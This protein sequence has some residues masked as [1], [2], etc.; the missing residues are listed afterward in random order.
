M[1]AGVMV[2]FSRRSRPTAG[3]SPL[4]AR[5]CLFWFGLP[6]C[7]ESGQRTA[8]GGCASRSYGL[9]LVGAVVDLACAAA[10]PPVDCSSR[11]QKETPYN[12]RTQRSGG[13]FMPGELCRNRD[14]SPLHGSGHKSGERPVHHIPVGSGT[15]APICGDGLQFLQCHGTHLGTSSG[16]YHY[17]ID[18]APRWRAP[19]APVGLVSAEAG[20]P[21]FQE[22]VPEVIS[23]LPAMGS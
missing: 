17:K 19:S 22:D 14:R 5:R 15:G 21:G 16:G 6:Y 3:A 8:G 2:R 18:T 7:F 20:A 23:T 11:T 4:S 9:S 13:I 10:G 1:S 12:P